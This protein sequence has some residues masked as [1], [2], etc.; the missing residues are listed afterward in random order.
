MKIDL[1][2]ADDKLKSNL[3][4]TPDPV[5]IRPPGAHGSKTLNTHVNKP[6]TARQYQIGETIE[7]NDIHRLYLI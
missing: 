1:F 2:S 3:E 7:Q 4:N 6:S 5:D